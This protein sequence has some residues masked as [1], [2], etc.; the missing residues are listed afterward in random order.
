MIIR[1]RLSLALGDERL[2]MAKRVLVA[3][4][5]ELMRRQVRTILESEADMEVC[6]EAADGREALQMLEECHPDVAVI[7]FQMP[8]MNG[9]ETVREIRKRLPTLPV[10]LM[11]LYGSDQLQRESELAGANAFLVK[12][13][14]ASR[15]PG[16]IRDLLPPQ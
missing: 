7:D 11:T 1:S 3:D 6:A 16:L 12:T 2:G 15:L 5:S 14:G 13:E 10:L 9:L 8:G 4:D